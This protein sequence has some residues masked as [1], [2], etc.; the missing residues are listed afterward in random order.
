MEVAY[1][2]LAQLLQLA[3]PGEAGLV[4]LRPQ[5]RPAWAYLL[6][7]EE[8]RWLDSSW[9]LERPPIPFS[10]LHPAAVMVSGA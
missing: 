9:G 3:V 1:P 2:A 10:A 5:A 4:S 7:V 8:P 6:Q